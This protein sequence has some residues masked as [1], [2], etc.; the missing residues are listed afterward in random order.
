MSLALVA[1]DGKL[2][3][4][5]Q[6]R[7]QIKRPLEL[8]KA[9]AWFFAQ[10]SPGIKRQR[11]AP[12]PPLG[13]MLTEVSPCVPV[14]VMCGWV[15]TACH[16]LAT[17]PAGMHVFYRTAG[18]WAAWTM[19]RVTQGRARGVQVRLQRRAAVPCAARF[20]PVLAC[21]VCLTHAAENA[22]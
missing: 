17:A 5:A 15:A 13:H 21:V 3:S 10:Q 7:A 12:P 4:P 19:E 16:R 2:Q 1:A 11:E 6:L 9:A 22:G 20:V 8:M 18:R 14:R